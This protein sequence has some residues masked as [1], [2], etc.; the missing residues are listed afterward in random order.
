MFDRCFSSTYV[1]VHLVERH[2]GGELDLLQNLIIAE[3]EGGG[4]VGAGDRADER[5]TLLR[6]LSVLATAPH[7]GVFEVPSYDLAV[8]AG[9]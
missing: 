4:P 2:A 7:L 1:A 5:C 3:A 6:V 9:C 8:E